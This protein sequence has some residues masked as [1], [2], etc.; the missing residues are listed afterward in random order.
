MTAAKLA[1]DGVPHQFEDLDAL[2]VIHA[3]RSAHVF[4]QVFVDLRIIEI[5]GA[6]RQIDQ[7]AGDVAFNNVFDFGVGITR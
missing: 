2:D 6:G 4:R 1:A 3:V 5:A 7:A